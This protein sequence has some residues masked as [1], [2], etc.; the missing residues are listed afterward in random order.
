MRITKTMALAAPTTTVRD[1]PQ[2]KPGQHFGIP[3]SVLIGRLTRCCALA[4]CS[5]VSS[6]QALRKSFC[7]R[8]LHLDRLSGRQGPDCNCN[9]NHSPGLFFNSSLIHIL[10]IYMKH[11]NSSTVDTWEVACKL[12]PR[13]IAMRAQDV[14]R[15]TVLRANI[16]PW[17]AHDDS[18]PQHLPNLYS[19][20]K[21]LSLCL[22]SKGATRGGPHQR[23]LLSYSSSLHG[24]RSQLTRC[25]GTR[26]GTCQY[27]PSIVSF[28]TPVIHFPHVSR[29]M[30]S[31]S[32]M[33][34]DFTA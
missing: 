7:I 32:L 21:P 26:V 16:I 23:A 1:M 3:S 33:M 13:P 19:N 10:M 20:L 11:P 15:S 2:Q 18:S 8:P 4:K 14:A 5:Q 12:G 22:K 31:S 30:V 27:E 28:Q 6:C 24:Q 29:F 34:R 9:N 17:V 25:V